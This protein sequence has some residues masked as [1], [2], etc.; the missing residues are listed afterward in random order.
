M[1]RYASDHAAR[2]ETMSENSRSFWSQ[3]FGNILVGLIGAVGAIV[4]AAVPIM[5]N[6]SAPPVAETRPV[7]TA[8]Q[9]EGATEAIAHSL[10]GTWDV[11]SNE[12]QTVVVTFDIDG[13]YKAGERVGVWTQTGLKFTQDMTTNGRRVHWEGEISPKGDEFTARNQHGR[14]VTG[15][16]R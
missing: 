16:K 14:Q 15:R 3:H 8:P 6:R 2:R 5:C 13:K 4:A 9:K 1:R 12:G 11:R 10:V 7:E